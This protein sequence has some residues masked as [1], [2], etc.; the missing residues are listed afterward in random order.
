MVRDLLISLGF[1]IFYL[2]SEGYLFSHDNCELVVFLKYITGSIHLGSSLTIS[3]FKESDINHRTAFV[4]FSYPF[5]KLGVG[6]AFFFAAHLIFSYFTILL[7]VKIWRSI[8]THTNIRSN[9]ISHYIVITFALFFVSNKLIPGDNPLLYNEFIPSTPANMFSL[10]FIYYI[11]DGIDKL[12]K[13][14]LISCGLCLGIASLFQ[15]LTGLSLFLMSVL[16][17]VSK[18]GALLTVTW[19]LSGGWILPYLFFT[20]KSIDEQE[21]FILT[22]FRGAHHYF[23][24]FFEEKKLISFVL[25]IVIAAISWH[26]LPKNIKY[27]VISFL[28]ILTLYVVLTLLMPTSFF[29][30]L[31]AWKMVPFFYII[32]MPYCI[33]GLSHFIRRELMF[34]ISILVFT[35]R[36]IHKAFSPPIFEFPFYSN[37]PHKPLVDTIRK[38]VPREAIILAPP[39]MYFL[40]GE[41]ERQLFFNYKAIPYKK[42]LILQWYSRLLLICP[43]TENTC[44]GISILNV[45]D[46][47]YSLHIKQIPID[48]LKYISVNYAIVPIWPSF[49]DS[50]CIYKDKKWALI[51]LKRYN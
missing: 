22:R 6:E 34:A 43:G 24:N 28:V 26:S 35:W 44:C 32:I 15:P 18:Q 38:H 48:E 37:A 51:S 19:I 33:I 13:R 10:M 5:F 23:L 1:L 29:V 31:Q 40:E 8:L 16:L 27:I 14:E 30:V 36:I 25:I 47:L 49:P 4:V 9:I 46:S 41:A 7:L 20:S 12:R 45:L 17:L 11:L 3:Q 21:I 39:S 2:V 50:L 42:G